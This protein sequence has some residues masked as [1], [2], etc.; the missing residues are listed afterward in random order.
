MYAVA[1]P[2][3]ALTK[4]WGKASGGI[5]LPATPSIAVTLAELRAATRVS[6]TDAGHGQYGSA[7]WPD[8]VRPPD[9]VYL[10]GREQSPEPFEPLFD[11]IR[12]LTG[13]TGGFEAR[14]VNNFPTAAGLASSAAGMA[15]LAA[16]CDGALGSGLPLEE[17]SAAARLGSGSAARAIFG[18]FVRLDAGASFARPLFDSD[19]WPAL[20]LLVVALESGPKPIGSRPAMVR[21]AETSPYYDAWLSDAGELTDRAEAALADR[22]LPTL[23]ETM[24]M[25]YLRMFA[26]MF[27]ASPPIIYWKPQT[28][29]LI[30]LLE[31][32]RRRG[33]PAWETMDA[34]PQV[35]ILLT[36]EHANR[37]T[38]EITKRLPGATTTV[39]T[40]GRGARIVDPSE[41]TEEERRHLEVK[42]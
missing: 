35:K 23:G 31:E 25:S 22:D 38:A 37:V 36:E 20:R 32:L 7:R 11:K 15:A 29:E 8:R 9:R 4:Y 14:S 33:I 39:C 19:H 42:G 13:Y 28:L 30:S 16:A 18:G 27:S 24:R 21:T 6:L 3:L 34:G 1:G 10:N 17:L 40:V 26:T 2:S 12:E 41:L 5:N